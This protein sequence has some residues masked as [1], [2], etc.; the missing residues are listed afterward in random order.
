MSTDKPD[1][2]QDAK[3]EIDRHNSS[4]DYTEWIRETNPPKEFIDALLNV[5]DDMVKNGLCALSHG[6]FF[7][8][9]VPVPFKENYYDGQ[10]GNRHERRR[11]AKLKRLDEKK[12]RRKERYELL[13]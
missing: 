2:Y 1:W 3:E 13:G 8:I 6:V 12:S 7:P 5:M 4:W 11:A 9:G 10:D